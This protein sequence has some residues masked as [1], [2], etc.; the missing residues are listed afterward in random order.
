MKI[1]GNTEKRGKSMIKNS[2]SYKINKSIFL[3][4]LQKCSD[5]DKIVLKLG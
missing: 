4:C 2:R 3:N 1:C 5:C